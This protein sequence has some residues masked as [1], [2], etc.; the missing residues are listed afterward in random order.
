MLAPSAARTAPVLRAVPAG[1]EAI[2]AI[3]LGSW[4]TFD[5]G[6]GEARHA[7]GEVL[8]AFFE[9][10]GRFVDSSPMYGESESL[11]GEEYARIGRP[12]GLFASTKVWTVG[13][14]AGD[15]KSVV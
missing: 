11:I 1:G 10:G 15:R 8:R 4:M 5:V 7:R 14:L 6:P 9:A 12:R 13:G 3:G 2:P